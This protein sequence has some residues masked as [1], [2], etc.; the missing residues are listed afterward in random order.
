MSRAQ[1]RKDPQPGENE[2]ELRVFSRD[3][4]VAWHHHRHADTDRMAIDRGNDWFRIVEHFE[5]KFSKKV[6]LAEPRALRGVF[7]LV[8]GLEVFEVDARAE[9]A[10]RTRQDDDAY[11]WL[12]MQAAK[13]V[14]DLFTVP[15]Y[16]AFGWFD[17]SVDATEEG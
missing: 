3:S 5:R 16:L 8:V 1:T 6:L 13:G 14:G 4:D 17:E 15:S 7:P 2:S 10:T 9:R 11:F 12:P